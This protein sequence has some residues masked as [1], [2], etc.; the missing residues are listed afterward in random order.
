MSAPHNPLDD[1][2]DDF[3]AHKMTTGE[4]KRKAKLYAKRG[5][6]FTERNGIFGNNIDG[7]RAD[8]FRT[9]LAMRG[10]L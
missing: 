9:V 3:G 7:K 4:L 8:A 6:A 10:E 2:L 5:R 1:L